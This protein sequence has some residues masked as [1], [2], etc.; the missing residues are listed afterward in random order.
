MPNLVAF[1]PSFPGQ[2]GIAHNKDEYMDEI[3]LLKNM[4]IYM[5][6]LI[7]LGQN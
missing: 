5:H 3:D 6:A 2:K 7:E 4:E 1:G